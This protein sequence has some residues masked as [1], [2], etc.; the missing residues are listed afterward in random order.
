MEIAV[1]V[2]RLVSA[3]RHVSDGWMPVQE[4]V[5]DHLE[6]RFSSGAYAN[7]RAALSKD[8]RLDPSLYLFCVR[9][10]GMHKGGRHNLPHELFFNSALEDI[11]DVI[12]R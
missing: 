5:F 3:V 8:L 6:Q 4:G 10:L 7:S 9:E 11:Y 2:D 1:A 12:R